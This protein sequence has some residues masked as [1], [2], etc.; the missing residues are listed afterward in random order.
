MKTYQH[1][2]EEERNQI[3]ILLNRKKTF[4]EIAKIVGRHVSTI[5]REVKKNHG[6]RR[7]R[8]HRA[9]QRA[10]E[11]HRQSHQRMRLKSHALRIEVEKLLIRG[12]S[13]E[14]IA[15][16]L[17]QR[18]D[19]PA[20]NPESI[21]QWIYAETP[22][23]K[24]YLVR[25]HS[26]RWHKGKGRKHKKSHIPYRISIQQR[27]QIINDRQQ[28]G[29][30]ETDLI[31]GKG[32]AAIQSSI[33]RQTRYTKLKKI[34]TK[35]AIVSRLALAS[36]LSPLPPHLRRSLTYD[37]G[38]ENT[39]HHLLNE[40]LNL[41]S[42]FCEPYHSWEKGTVENNNGLIRRFF[43]KQTNFDNISDQQI[44]QVESW[45]NHRPRKCLNFKLPTEAFNALCCT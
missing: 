27:P 28:E 33:E 26:H 40:S 44:Q 43:P 30:W 13:P 2:T 10:M 18:F 19:L 15:G 22:H 1:I 29:H 21:Y 31:V 5:S 45:L 34:P 20:T 6:R 17:K 16:R 38:S 41:Q 36:Q 8:A 37:N 11:N 4:R 12:W 32:K 9:H 3:L 42:Y 14:L 24:G 35:T 7:Y 39:E 25:Q 23:L